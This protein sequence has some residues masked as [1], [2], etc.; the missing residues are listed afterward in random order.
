MIVFIKKKNSDAF[1]SWPVTE[2]TDSLLPFTAEIAVFSYHHVCL[3]IGTCVSEHQKLVCT[4]RPI[5]PPL[6]HHGNVLAAQ[7]A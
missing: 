5:I 4:D 3:C 7:E 6:C 2:A 1:L